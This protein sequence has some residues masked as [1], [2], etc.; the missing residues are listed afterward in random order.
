M[1]TPASNKQV[2]EWRKLGQKKFRQASG[3]YL[4]EGDHLIEEAIRAG[5]DIIEYIATESALDTYAHLFRECDVTVISKQIARD[6][7]DTMTSQEVFATVKMPNVDSISHQLSKVLVCDGVQD[8]GNLGTM[9]RSAD[10]AGFDGVVLGK[11]TVDMYNPKVLRAAQGSHF[12]IPIIT[13]DLE[14]WLPDMKT[15]GMVIYGTSV[16]DSASPYQQVPMEDVSLGLIVGNEGNGIQSSVLQLTD[17]LLYIPMK[18]QAES[19]NVAIA[20]SILMFHFMNH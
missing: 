8:P 2:K 19:L 11:G 10:A 6:I 20:A 1:L 16:D 12:H 13:V 7:S 17:R 15:Q 18:G 3:M 4:I 5:A 14:Q 9:I